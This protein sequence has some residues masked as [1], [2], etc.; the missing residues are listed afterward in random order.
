MKISRSEGSTQIVNSTLEELEQAWAALIRQEHLSTSQNIYYYTKMYPKTGFYKLHHSRIQLIVT[1]MVNNEKHHFQQSRTSSSD[2]LIGA[3]K[4]NL[5]VYMENLKL[6]KTDALMRSYR[7][8][9]PVNVL[10]QLPNNLK[11]LLF[12]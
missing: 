4:G 7:S 10:N 12:E 5:A 9:D 6:W 1:I 3:F 11:F 2:L 8:V